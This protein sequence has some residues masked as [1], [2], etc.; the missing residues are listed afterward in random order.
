MSKTLMDI[1]QAFTQQYKGLL[2][3]QRN[4]SHALENYRFDLTTDEITRAVKERMMAF[5]YFNVHNCADLGRE[6]NTVAA[7]F[8]TET[9]LFFLKNC[10]KS[11]GLEVVSE[12]D[13]RIDKNGRKEIRPDISIWKKRDPMLFDE[14]VA[15][16]ELKVSNGWKGKTIY[17][18]LENRK[19]EIRNIYSGVF[20]GVISFWNCF[21][22]GFKSNDNS[23]Y[24]GLYNFKSNPKGDHSSTKLTIE[25]L[26]R[27]IVGE[28]LG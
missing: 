27:Q 23:E 18:H 25:Q 15:V 28:T 11:Y 17:Q 22:D 9:C 16:I 5:W 8:F 6:V 24:I 14:L 3:T 19:K 21:G 4:I 20:F 7:D 26:L 1:D 13:I 2:E 10:L 12:R